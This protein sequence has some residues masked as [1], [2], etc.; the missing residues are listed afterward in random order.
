MRGLLQH[1]RS[2]VRQRCKGVLEH[3]VLLGLR[4]RLLMW[5]L[6]QQGPLLLQGLCAQKFLRLLQSLCRQRLL[7]RWLLRLP[8]FALRCLLMAQQVRCWLGLGRRLL[9][10]RR[11]W[12]KQALRSVKQ[13]LLLLPRAKLLWWLPLP[14]CQPPLLHLQH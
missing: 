14:L 7:L 10:L 2:R 13:A 6:L 4:W 11:R 9:Q 1:L 5:W 12:V 3:L 8:H